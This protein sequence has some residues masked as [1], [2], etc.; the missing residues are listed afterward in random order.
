MHNSSRAKSEVNNKNT[1]KY[2]NICNGTNV[3]H[4]HMESDWSILC[5]KHRTSLKK[6][7]DLD[8][9]YFSKIYARPLDLDPNVYT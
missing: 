8:H 5:K 7:L 2:T 1:R 9:R 6:N 4:L 3:F